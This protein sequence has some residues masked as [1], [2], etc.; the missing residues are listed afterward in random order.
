MVPSGLLQSCWGGETQR[1]GL[2]AVFALCVLP[3]GRALQGEMRVSIS[4]LPPKPST[5]LEGSAR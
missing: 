3:A 2:F 4:L 1:K 5:G